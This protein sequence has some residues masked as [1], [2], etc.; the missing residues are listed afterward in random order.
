MDSSKELKIKQKHN[1]K[2]KNKH[3]L[4]SIEQQANLELEKI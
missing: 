4:E 3:Q 1:N 2:H